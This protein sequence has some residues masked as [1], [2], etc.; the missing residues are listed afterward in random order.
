M[1]HI[2]LNVISR[3][4]NSTLRQFQD[5]G[6]YTGILIETDTK[7][8]DNFNGEEQRMGLRRVRKEEDSF[9]TNKLFHGVK[10]AMSLRAKSVNVST[11]C[12]LGTRTEEVDQEDKRYFYCIF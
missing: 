1:E 11:L 5:N 9:L 8:Q 12:Q 6:V 10:V 7:Q 4:I 3:H 2:F